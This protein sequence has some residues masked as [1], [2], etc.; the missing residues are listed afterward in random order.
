MNSKHLLKG[1]FLEIMQRRGVSPHLFLIHQQSL[2]CNKNKKPALISGSE[3]L[4]TINTKTL[5]PS[6]TKDTKKN[7]RSIWRNLSS[8]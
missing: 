3:Q 1:L 6:Q 5:C 4:V 7:I 8:P 2:F